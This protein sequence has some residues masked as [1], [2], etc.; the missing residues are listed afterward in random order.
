VVRLASNIISS[1]CE[2]LHIKER[3]ERVAMCVL[4]RAKDVA[5]DRSMFGHA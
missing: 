3:E 5:M 1:S 4:W 2:E